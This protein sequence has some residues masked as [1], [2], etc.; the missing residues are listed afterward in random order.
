MSH[1]VGVQLRVKNFPALRRTLLQF[2]DLELMEGQTTFKWFGQWM[3][4]Y[5]SADAAYKLGIKPEDY[6][7]CVHAI[8]MRNNSDAYE[9]GV[10]PAA[11]G[12]GFILVFD[13][14]GQENNIT[15]ICGGQDLRQFT[16]AYQREVVMEDPAIRELVNKGFH[17]VQDRFQNG[18]L[19]VRVTND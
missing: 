17:I 15:R 14:W 10:M 16:Q 9:I 5:G 4:D 6:G 3:N 11:D 18:D 2:P 8:R 12:D 1:V 7:K 19:R 13:F